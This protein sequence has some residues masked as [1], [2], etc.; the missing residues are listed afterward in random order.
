MKDAPSLNLPNSH[1]LVKPFP[2]TEQGEAASQNLAEMLN[3]LPF[4]FSLKAAS[5][6]L[7]LMP[8]R[9]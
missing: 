7:N 4:D 8:V 5:N 6:P 9:F 2:I 3:D 1:S